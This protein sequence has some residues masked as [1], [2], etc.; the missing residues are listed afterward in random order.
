M[1][2]AIRF[3]TPSGHIMEIYAQMDKVGN[4]LPMF[5]PRRCP[6]TWSASRRP[7]ST[8]AC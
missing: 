8:T 2:D 5:N 4:G 6:W 7:G 3:D 1:G